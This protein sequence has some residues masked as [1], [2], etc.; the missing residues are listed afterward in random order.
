[1]NQKNL[2]STNRLL[3]KYLGPFASSSRTCQDPPTDIQVVPCPFPPDLPWRI[4]NKLNEI[5]EKIMSETKPTGRN[6]STPLCAERDPELRMQEHN[7]KS[8]SMNRFVTLYLCP[9]SHQRYS[10]SACRIRSLTL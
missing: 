8:I 6:R 4:Q 7:T 3:S 9:I 1:M 2:K 10:I 5:I